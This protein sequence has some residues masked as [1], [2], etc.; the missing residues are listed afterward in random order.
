MGNGLCGEQGCS[1]NC[2]GRGVNHHNNNPSRGG[3]ITYFDPETI[4]REFTRRIRG[5]HVSEYCKHDVVVCDNGEETGG[6][7]D[8]SCVEA[9][10]GDVSG[11]QLAEYY[12]A[13][14]M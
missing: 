2:G 7:D 13:N 6:G 1:T 14:T 3:C 9:D 8:G 11:V 4:S 12:T 10:G 5:G